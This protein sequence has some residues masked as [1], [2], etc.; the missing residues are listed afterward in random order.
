MPAWLARTW[1]RPEPRPA[2]TVRP[3]R[4]W[5]PLL[6]AG[7]PDVQVCA[8][9]QDGVEFGFEALHPGIGLGSLC[10]HFRSE[11]VAHVF[12]SFLQGAAH[13]SDSG[14]VEPGSCED[15]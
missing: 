6:E 11:G 1:K 7:N 2:A 8:D 4:G 5:L 10:A 12:D 15:A 3:A 9:F 14:V 13:V